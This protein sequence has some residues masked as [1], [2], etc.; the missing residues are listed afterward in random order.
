MS[1]LPEQV[2]V[3]ARQVLPD[4]QLAPP[5]FQGRTPAVFKVP[6]PSITQCLFPTQA[7]GVLS[8]LGQIALIFFMFLVGVG[9]DLGSLK[10]LNTSANLDLSSQVAWSTTIGLDMGKLNGFSLR[11]GGA[12]QTTIKSTTAPAAARPTTSAVTASRTA[13]RISAV[14]SC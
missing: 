1:A 9:L 3:S 5:R 14:T 13:H 6:P 12:Y 4:E 11:A 8:I 10:G 7:R 2:E